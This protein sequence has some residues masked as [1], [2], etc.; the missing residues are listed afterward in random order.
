MLSAL[1]DNLTKLEDLSICECPEVEELPSF[2][3]LSN[4]K[5]IA[6]NSCEKLHNI[7]LPTT[8][9]EL[10]VQGCRE[11][12]RVAISERPKV[13]ELPI[14]ARMYCLKSIS[15]DS[16]EKL[17][18]IEGT[19]ELQELEA[20]QFLYCSNA[21]IQNCITKLKRMPSAFI[22]VVG[23]AANGAQSNLNPFSL[24]EAYLCHSD[25]WQSVSAM[26]MCCVV[27]V[28]SSTPFH[29][30]NESLKHFMC[31]FNLRQGGWIITT[32]T[33]SQTIYRRLDREFSDLRKQGI[34][35]K[36]SA[37]GV[38][39]GEDWRIFHALTTIIN[40]LHQK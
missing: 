26:I 28:T 21:G 29:T 2:A 14:L 1:I 23:R 17:E 18:N 19:E 34:M 5:M 8:V 11:L 16:C 7:T 22:Q 4:L 15:I 27:V 9:I 33:S 40:K 24:S 37:W 6:I 35:M 30:I 36:W 38:K 31:K 13:G 3:K 12:H 25:D 10:T 39:K 20:I 32:I